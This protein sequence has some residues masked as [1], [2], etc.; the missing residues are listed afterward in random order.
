MIRYLIFGVLYRAAITVKNQARL[1]LVQ[2]S[3][4]IDR[5]EAFGRIAFSCPKAEVSLSLEPRPVLL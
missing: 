4:S 2:I 1:E 5:A 3:E